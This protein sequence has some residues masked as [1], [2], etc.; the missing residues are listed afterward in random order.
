VSGTVVLSFIQDVERVKTIALKRPSANDA[1]LP[2]EDKCSSSISYPEKSKD[3]AGGVSDL[4][5]ET[6]VQKAGRN[7]TSSGIYVH[8]G[9]AAAI[10]CP[11]FNMTYEAAHAICSCILALARAMTLIIRMSVPSSDTGMK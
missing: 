2:P 4:L 5:S 8:R 1:D 6:I 9:S 11:I 7:G 10:Q 3:Q